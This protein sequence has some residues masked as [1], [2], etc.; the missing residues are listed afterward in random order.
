M[1]RECELTEEMKSETAIVPAFR[2]SSVT[3]RDLGVQVK[4]KHLG[5]GSCILLHSFLFFLPVL[6]NNRVFTPVLNNGWL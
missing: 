2:V 3:S 6:G 5:C 1:L 4:A